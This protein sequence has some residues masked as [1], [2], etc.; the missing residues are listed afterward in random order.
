[1]RFVERLEFSA[2][3]NEVWER[4]SNLQTVPTYWHGTREFSPTTSGGRITADVVFAFGGKGKAE[5]I[6]DNQERTL[7]F[8]YLAGPFE[9]IQKVVV[10][11][12]AIEAEWDVAFKGAYK[13]LGPWNVSHFRSGTKHALERLCEGLTAAA[14]SVS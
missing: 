8:E 6:V 13:V 14:P 2:D 12:N 9:G 10:K 1:V 7:A 5:V 3:P 4:L 11:K